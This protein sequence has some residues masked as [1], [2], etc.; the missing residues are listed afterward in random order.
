MTIA[1]L[2]N[3]AIDE[4]VAVTGTIN[5]GGIIGPVGGIRAKMNIAAET[6]LTKVLVPFSSS[7]SE[8]NVTIDIQ[9][10][11]DNISIEVVEVSNIRQALYEFTGKM[12]ERP[13]QP[14]EINPSYENTM[15]DIYSILCDRTTE[16]FEEV[17]KLDVNNS[18]L[19]EAKNLSQSANAALANEAYYPAASYCFGANIKLRSILI[20]DIPQDN[21]VAQMNNLKTELKEF[22][23]E[24]DGKEIKTITDLQTKIIVKERILD[25]NNILNIAFEK[26]EE[27]QNSTDNF[28]YAMERLFS[29]QVWA[30]FFGKGD[31]KLELKESQIKESCLNKVSE[32]E[33]RFQYVNLLTPFTLEDTRKQLDL[34]YKDYENEDYEL[35]LFKASKSKA[36]LDVT[37][38]ALN[39]AEDAIPYLIDEK[40]KAAEEQI[41]EESDK[42]RFPILGYSYYLY[43]K[44]LKETNEISSLIYAELALE[45]SNLWPYFKERQIY[46]E[47]SLDLK[48]IQIFLAGILIGILIMLGPMLK[49]RFRKK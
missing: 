28:A 46:Q 9:E 32:A 39:V 22:E 26:I 45:L 40:L 33:E 35:C 7:I 30:N 48:S 47:P 49:A 43:S 3:I 6:G 19:Y 41:I 20:E 1:L 5:S 31:Q 37:L 25:A 12:Y 17:D 13:P 38:S 15:R 36:E 44:D 14:L 27:K 2:E 4:T 21:I 10:Y 42:G 34:A 11:A 29:A 8:E 16:L 23:A 24:I 18:L